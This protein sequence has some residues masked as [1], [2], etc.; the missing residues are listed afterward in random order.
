VRCRRWSRSFAAFYFRDG[1]LIAC[2]AVNRPQEF[3]IAKRMV[4]MC[5]SFDVAALA[6]ESHPLKAFVDSLQPTQ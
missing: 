3:F 2:D 5:Q 6:D 4:A 1:K